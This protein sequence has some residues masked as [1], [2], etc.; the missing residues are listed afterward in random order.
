MLARVLSPA[1]T[2]TNAR[3]HCYREYQFAI[4][5]RDIEAGKIVNSAGFARG[6][7]NYRIESL[8]FNVVGT[9]VRNCEDSPTPSSCYAG[10]F[11][12][13]TLEHLGP[14]RVRNYEGHDVRVE[15]FPGVIEH[16]RALGAERY[17]TNPL[18]S[19]DLQLI[20]PYYR[21]ELRGRPLDGRF[22]LRIWEEE[23]VDFSA[24]QDIQL[25]L[26]YRYWTRFE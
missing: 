23:A 5:P 2:D 6:N 16:A 11:V 14:Y 7:F 15:L 3:T 26:N 13:F 21:R 17:V 1:C 24:I 22:V 4:S 12:P 20:E 8:G 10:G 18:S 9:G 19:A 25:I